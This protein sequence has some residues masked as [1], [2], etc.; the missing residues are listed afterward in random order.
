MCFNNPSEF[1]KFLG[2][3]DDFF[4]ICNEAEELISEWSN[5]YVG[6]I[7]TTQDYEFKGKMEAKNAECEKVSYQLVGL[8]G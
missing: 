8:L 6:K 5:N 4:E 2:L 1:K 3:R 7:L